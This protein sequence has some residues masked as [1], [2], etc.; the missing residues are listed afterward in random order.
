MWG[1]AGPSQ[2]DVALDIMAVAGVIL[3]GGRSVRMGS[4][5]ALLD[6]RGAP[7]VVRILEVLEALDVR[8][9]VV[10]V[11]PLGADIRAAVSAR[12]CTIVENPDIDGGPIASL[13]AALR[14]LRPLRVTGALVWPVDLPHVRVTTVA[15]LLDAHRRE[16]ALATVPTYGGRRGHPVVWDESAWDD[17]LTH[18]A[19]PRG[20]ARRARRRC[21]RHRHPEL[22]AGLRTPDW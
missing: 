20:G 13:G 18:P 5:K 8:P 15:Q 9:R 2:L 3:A 16:R 21:S 19:A 10:V 22:P 12:G 14:V 7:F 1:F 11:S 17:L 6:F 4:P